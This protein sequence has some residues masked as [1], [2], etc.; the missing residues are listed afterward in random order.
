MPRPIPLF[1][2]AVLAC[3]CAS[4]RPCRETVTAG[5]MD[6]TGLDRAV[7]T[8][9]DRPYS[10]TRTLEGVVLKSTVTFEG[11][12][13]GRY[14]LTV[15]DLAGNAATARKRVGRGEWTG[16]TRGRLAWPR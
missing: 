16:A 15:Y 6:E 14:A 9:L 7:L 12:C 2:A 1:L 10:S 4:A 11:V 5:L 13:P 3:G 8:A